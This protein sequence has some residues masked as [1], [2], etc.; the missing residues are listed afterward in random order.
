M[1]KYF[2]LLVIDT[3]SKTNETG[4]V[5]ISNNHHKGLY[6]GE[7]ENNAVEWFKTI[8]PDIKDTDW[9]RSV[10][11]CD[12]ITKWVNISRESVTE[13]KDHNWTREFIKGCVTGIA[14]IVT[15]ITIQFFLK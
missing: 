7:S 10:I 6:T 1:T 12:D 15:Y 2:S 11:S 14:A 9:K 8:L 13:N 5:D 3:K 4:S